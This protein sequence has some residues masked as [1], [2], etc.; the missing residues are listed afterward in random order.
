MDYLERSSSRRLSAVVVVSLALSA[1]ACGDARSGQSGEAG[2]DQSGDAAAARSEVPVQEILA[3]PGLGLPHRVEPACP[4]EGCTFGT[5]LACD[6]VPLYA[7]P[8]DASA[9]ASVLPPNEPFEVATGMVIVDVPEVVVVTRPTPQ[10]SFEEDGVTFQPGDTLYVLDYLGEGFFNAWYVDTIL[11]TEVF[12][13]WASFFPGSDFVYGGE[14]VQTGAASFWVRTTDEEGAAAW[15][16]VD[17]A[18]VAAPSLLEP[19]FL[20]CPTAP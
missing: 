12:W 15:V 8:G 16:W 3:P 4:G 1:I 11:E 17:S 5:W 18:S 9:T 19:G 2:P 6:S 13:P 20:E 14:V 10:I 7:S